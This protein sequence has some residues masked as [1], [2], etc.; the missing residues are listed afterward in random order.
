LTQFRRPRGKLKTW[1]LAAAAAATFT[2]GR[3]DA[4]TYTYVDQPFLPTASN[5]GGV[6][7][8][9]MR[10]ARFMPDGYLS[11]TGVLKSPDDRIALTFQALPWLEATIRYTID[12]ALP[13]P[14]QRALYS[15]EFDLKARLFQ[16]TEYTPQVAVGLQDIIGTGQYSAEYLV[17][18]KYV[19]PFDL[20]AGLGWGALAQRDTFENPLCAA[21]TG[22]CDRPAF[23]GQGGTLTLDY[24]RGRQTGLFYGVEYQTPI[25]KLTFKIEYSTYA[26]REESEVQ[27]IDY[28]RIP[29]DVGLSYRFWSD[30]DVGLEYMGG[31]ELALSV[32]MAM[33]PSKP[34]FPSRIDDMPP[35]TARSEADA[36]AA[37]TEIDIAA[38]G[39][40]VP[41]MRTDAALLRPTAPITKPVVAS[42]GYQAEGSPQVT[43]PGDEPWRV[44][45]VD[46]TAPDPVP[47]IRPPDPA[48]SSAS[49]GDEN[50]GRLLRD[51]GLHVT[52]NWIDGRTLVVQIDNRPVRDTGSIC[53]SLTAQGRSI[54]GVQEIALVGS[55]WN[56][57]KFC[58]STPTRAQTI[59]AAAV[60]NSF[61]TV[62]TTVSKPELIR[63]LRAAIEA[64]KLI[65]EG[66]AINGTVIEVEIENERYLR[67]AEAISRTVRAMSAVAPADITAFRVTTSIDQMPLTTVTMSRREV[68]A[69]ADSSATPAEIWSASVPG[70]ASPSIDYGNGRGFPRFGWSIFPSLQKELFDPNNPVYIG[71]GISG[72]THTELLPGLTFDAE[73]TYDFFNNFG[74]ITRTSNSALP[75]VRSDAALYLKYG[76]TGIDDV[77]LSYYS[78]LAPDVY[79]RASGGY[80]ESMFGG[81]GGEVLYRPFGSR[82]AVGVDMWQVWQRNFNDLFGFQNYNIATGHVS[83]Y[84]ETPWYDVTAVLRGG[85]YLAGDYGATFEIYRRF[86]T[87]ILI[88]GWFTLTNVPFSEFGEGSFDKGIRIVIPMEWVLPFGASTTEDLDL[89]PVERDGGQRLE[90]DTTLFDMTQTSSEGDLQRQWPSVF[91]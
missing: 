27:H 77:T 73:A 3:A 40:P 15:R 81:A 25:P 60:V 83:L 44:H 89:R 34:N 52:D 72:S 78:K 7:L 4:Q 30:V 56:P 23:T 39:G 31:R 22:F 53:E 43:E 88:G 82:F 87:G 69:L 62:T 57:I 6:G 70:D 79:A 42:A 59:A 12:Y 8:L 80:I 54:S 65:V 37:Q 46:L 51:A 64:Q 45:F 86:D 17:A 10:N 91:K 38:G 32:S 41:A 29:V 63:K 36:V 18:S 13:P 9:D 11:L 76:A 50:V 14:Q 84:W 20:T 90:N 19:G 28:E 75:H 5:Y 55:D 58:D 67:D 1:L 49:A 35:F 48:M 33:D 21:Y 71:V 24:F 2:E 66:I 47:D 26:Y 68:D 61:M 74:S 16:E 85:R